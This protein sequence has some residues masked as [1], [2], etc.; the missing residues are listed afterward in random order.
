[1]SALP[2]AV[3]STG[4]RWITA[5]ASSASS[6]RTGSRQRRANKFDARVQAGVRVLS[7]AADRMPGSDQL[8]CDQPPDGAGGVGNQD[9]HLGLTSPNVILDNR[10]VA[11]RLARPLLRSTAL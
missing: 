5:S 3:V 7:N 4:A 2:G 1:M 6:C 9:L 10:Q 11:H 8:P